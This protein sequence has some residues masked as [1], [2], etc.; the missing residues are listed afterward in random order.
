MAEKK[1]KQKNQ[2]IC[3]NKKITKHNWLV[4]F[5]EIVFICSSPN[6]I[7]KINVQNIQSLPANERPLFCEK[8]AP[9]HDI[10]IYAQWSVAQ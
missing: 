2:L 9:T 5:N 1:Q 7:L 10:Y 4:Q 6:F 3:H 8:I